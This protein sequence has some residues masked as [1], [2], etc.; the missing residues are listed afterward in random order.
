MVG[1]FTVSV[2]SRGWRETVVV[3]AVLDDVM[4]VMLV[5][6][7]APL[8]YFV[9]RASGVML[10]QSQWWGWLTCPVVPWLARA[11]RRIRGVVV[12]SYMLYNG[13]DVHNDLYYHRVCRV[14]AHVCV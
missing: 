4:H 14:S 11:C 9:P 13:S 12:E 3:Q 7:D 10:A 2:Q 8:V 5:A 1:S 6:D